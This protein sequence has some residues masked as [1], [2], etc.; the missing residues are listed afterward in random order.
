MCFLGHS[1]QISESIIT[2][3]GFEDILKAQTSQG[4]E[5]S[6]TASSDHHPVSIDQSLFGQIDCTL[7]AI[8]DVYDAPLP[9][10]SIAVGSAVIS[11]AAIINTG[12]SKSSGCPVLNGRVP[13]VGPPWLITING[14][15]SSSIPVKR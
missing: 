12:D 1:T 4:G 11:A 3:T 9:P 10:Q 5:S 14:G 6:G 2:G 15:N 7:S 13:E 8:L